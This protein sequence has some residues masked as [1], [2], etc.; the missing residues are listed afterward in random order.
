[1]AIF[2]DLLTGMT[3]S[4]VRC[5]LLSHS[6]DKLNSCFV[7][8][9]PRVTPPVRRHST[10]T[11]SL[12]PVSIL[13]FV[14]ASAAWRCGRSP[15]G[16]A[17]RLIPVLCRRDLDAFLSESSLPG[18]WGAAN[19]GSLWLHAVAAP[20]AA[21]GARLLVAVMAPSITT[22][23]GARLGLFPITAPRVCVFCIGCLDFPCLLPLVVG[24]RLAAFADP[25]PALGRHEDSGGRVCR[26]R[27][28]Y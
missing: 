22:A 12:L 8:K 17:A 2:R 7:T 19:A 16:F 6:G 10:V 5:R 14:I 20:G 28:R 4:S 11:S 25:V 1:M 9:C 24:S 15:R 27:I 23:N 3:C 13:G 26:N 21:L 18:K